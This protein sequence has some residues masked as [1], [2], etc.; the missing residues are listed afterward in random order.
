MLCQL[1]GNKAGGN[2]KK[3]ETS[4]VDTLYWTSRLQ[5]YAKVNFVN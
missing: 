4:P 3:K 5:N 1:Y 2:I